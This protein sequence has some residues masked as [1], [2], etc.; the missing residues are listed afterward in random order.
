MIP[1]FIKYGIGFAVAF[2]AVV[3]FPRTLERLLATGQLS[4]S[5]A[6]RANRIAWVGA[7]LLVALTGVRFWLARE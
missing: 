2:Y 7:L 5:A 1:S 6:S 4:P 3:I